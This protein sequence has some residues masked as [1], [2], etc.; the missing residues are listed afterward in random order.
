[1]KSACAQR[2]R[3]LV[4]AH[5]QTRCSLWRARPPSLYVC[6]LIT[7]VPKH[8]FRKATLSSRPAHHLPRKGAAAWRHRPQLL[9]RRTQRCGAS[10]TSGPALRKY[11][12]RHGHGC[13][14]IQSRDCVHRMYNIGYT[15][16]RLAC[17]ENA[18]SPCIDADRPTSLQS[19]PAASNGG[20]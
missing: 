13:S 2:L 5:R 14:Q 17:R 6:S 16:L 19:L 18:A 12:R 4:Y 9:L 10:R 20:V 7:L 8:T 1:M 11:W 3:S 15:Y